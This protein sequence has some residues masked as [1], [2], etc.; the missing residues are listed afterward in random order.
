M[1]DSSKRILVVDDLQVFLDLQKNFLQNA[2]YIVETAASGREALEKAH[3]Y[4]PHLILLDLYMPGMDG[5]ACCALIKK[6]PN[7]KNI[8]V[9]ITTSKGGEEDLMRCIE[10]G[11]DGYLKK[12]VNH[13]EFLAEVQRALNAKVRSHSAWPIAV[14]VRYGPLDAPEHDGITLN[15]S[16]TGMFIRAEKPPEVG[17][18]LRLEFDLPR[19]DHHFQLSG[20][21]VRSADKTNAGALAAGFDVHFMDVDALSSRLIKDYFKERAQRKR[22]TSPKSKRRIVVAD[23]SRFWRDK[24]MGMLSKSGHEVIAVEDGESVI[25]LAMDPAHSVDLVVLDLVMPSV[26]GFAVAR[27][28]RNEE[29]TEKITIVGFTGVY[30]RDDFP[31]GTREHGFNAVIEKSASTDEFL[32]VFNRYLETP[33][34]PSDHRPATRVPSHLP[35]TYQCEGGRRASCV[36]TNISSSGAYVST[37]SP[38]KAGTEVCLMFTLPEGPM[39]RTLAKVVWMNAVAYGSPATYSMGMGVVFTNTEPDTQA[40]LDQYIQAESQRY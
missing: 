12:I 16:A 13:T 9:V 31:N 25:R 27:Y 21:V 3:A 20:E 18:I 5:A 11:C 15:I 30:S 29:L 1:A 10:A 36:V 22:F 23:D 33:P 2:G 26:D 37:S 39:I 32:F 14:N 7:L 28:L 4:R 35:A 19:L 6:D 34:P 17:T 40:A 8:P 24:V 38:L